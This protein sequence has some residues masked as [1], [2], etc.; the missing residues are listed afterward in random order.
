MAETKAWISVLR[1]ILYERDF[2]TF[3]I[4]PR[5]GRIAWLRGLRAS[6]AEPPAEFPSTMKSSHSRG[7]FDEQSTSFPGSP[8]PSRALLRR[9]RSRAWRAAIRAREAWTALA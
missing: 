7:S 8:A 2:S 9:V 4:L 1:K 6:F 3:K 5:I